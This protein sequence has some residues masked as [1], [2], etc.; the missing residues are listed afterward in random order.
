LEEENVLNNG[1]VSYMAVPTLIVRLK[2]LF[3]VGKR[4]IHAMLKAAVPHTIVTAF[5]RLYQ[6]PY[7]V[8][9]LG[10]T[11]REREE[12]EAIVMQKFNVL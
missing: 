4:S 7:V 3:R 1:L 6:S 12:R 5:P 11:Q 10:L 8:N 9:V 2:I